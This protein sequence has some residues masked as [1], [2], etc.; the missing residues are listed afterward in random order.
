MLTWFHK[1]GFWLGPIPGGL[2]EVLG[3][4]GVGAVPQHSG[5]PDRRRPSRREG[6]LIVGVS[7]ASYGPVSW[8]IWYRVGMHTSTHTYIY[9]YVCIYTKTRYPY[10]SVRYLRV[11][12]CTYIYMY[13]YLSLY[14]YMYMYVY[15]HVD[16]SA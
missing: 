15:V 2:L 9:I 1:F 4:S 16:L 5:I 7:L 6:P 12:I 11:C 10:T 3:T 13:K 14:I 8:D